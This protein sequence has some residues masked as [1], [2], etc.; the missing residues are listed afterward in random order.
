LWGA[1]VLFD[2]FALGFDVYLMLELSTIGLQI[3]SARCTDV[4]LDVETTHTDGAMAFGAEVKL[5]LYLRPGF[6][7]GIGLLGVPFGT[8]HLFTSLGSTPPKAAKQPYANVHDVRD[9]ADS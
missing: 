5:V 6:L 2:L 8:I 9:G 7:Q 4:E 3:W 1:V